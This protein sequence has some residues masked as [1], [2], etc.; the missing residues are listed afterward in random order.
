MDNK[1]KVTYLIF[2]GKSQ[3][4]TVRAF[5]RYSFFENLDQVIPDFSLLESKIFTVDRV[6]NKPI[7]AKYT[8]KSVKNYTLIKLYAYA[9]AFDSNR[10]AGSI[11]GV[12]FLSEGN[13]CLCPDNIKLLKDVTDFFAEICL[14]N[15]KFKN[16]DFKSEVIGIWRQFCDL[17]G[18]SK[19]RYVEN[20]RPVKKETIGVYVQS[21]VDAE[22][23]N[24]ERMYF[25]ED[26]EH[27][28]RTH[29]IWKDRFV[30]CHKV[31]GEYIVYK[32]PNPTQSKQLS[33][34]TEP[35][36]DDLHTIVEQ[37]SKINALKFENHK[38]RKAKRKFKRLSYF[39]ALLL[40]ATLAVVA[41]RFY[42]GEMDGA[43]VRH[44]KFLQEQV[45]L[46]KKETQKNTEAIKSLAKEIE[47]L[48]QT[49]DK[50]NNNNKNENHKQ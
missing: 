22:D 43:G 30:I 2:F 8:F 34:K 1:E 38:I 42:G 12:A 33:S 48:R 19:I 4:F 9:Q 49:I 16:S 44:L 46:T 39:L 27:L 10:V 25:S 50:M 41:V 26:L 7:L 28:K 13:L 6:D 15:N 31:K 32:E 35:D 45:E 36:S 37:T 20:A 11:Y 21:I 47:Q 23:L 40:I 3:S 5:D 18:F 14:Q 17:G 24:F 29:E